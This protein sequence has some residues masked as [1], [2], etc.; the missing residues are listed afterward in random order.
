MSYPNLHVEVTIR[1]YDGSEE[2]AL[3]PIRKRDET[4]IWKVVNE[5]FDC[6]GGIATYRAIIYSETVPIYSWDHVLWNRTIKIGDY[7]VC[8][9]KSTE[10]DEDA[11]DLEK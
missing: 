9:E 4:C 3:F 1:Y 8:E 6:T 11:G 2:I 5:F 10:D 7:K